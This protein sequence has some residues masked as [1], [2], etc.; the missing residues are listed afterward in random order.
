M[1]EVHQRSRGYYG[2]PR[3][4]SQLRLQGLTLGRRR[5]GRLMR[6]AALQ[7][8]SA[9]LYRCSKVG[10]KAFFTSL[11]NRQ[12]ELHVARPDQLW[13]GDVT[14]LRVNGQWRYQRHR[15]ILEMRRQPVGDAA[16]EE[17]LSLR[18]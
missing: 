3:V 6:L 17:H 8:R 11:P 13:V 18:K 10:Q 4:T 5:V 7:G 2:S 16:G 1:R 15:P 14:Y 9:R 12:R